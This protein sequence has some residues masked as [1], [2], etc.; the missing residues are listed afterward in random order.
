MAFPRSIPS[1]TCLCQEHMLTLKLVNLGSADEELGSIGPPAK[2]QPWMAIMLLHEVL[3][4]KFIIVDRFANCTIPYGEVS[5]L[6]HKIRNHTMEAPSLLEPG[7]D[8]FLDAFLA[9][10]KGT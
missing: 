5:T 9:G 2:H 6:A 4:H 8:G 3:I 7:I 1:T 10:S